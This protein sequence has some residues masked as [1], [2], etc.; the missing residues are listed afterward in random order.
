MKLGESDLK[1][2][3][4]PVFFGYLLGVLTVT[5][6]FLI[7]CSWLVYTIGFSNVVKNFKHTVFPWVEQKVIDLPEAMLQ[8]LTTISAGIEN[9]GNPTNL[10]PHN[11][12]FVSAD[13]ELGHKIKPNVRI[14]ASILKTTKAF[15]FDPPILFYRYDADL[16]DD[17]KAFINSQ[18]RHHFSYSSD[19]DGFRKTLPIVNADKGVLII[20]DSV[21][22]GVGVD[23]K[24]T[25]A[26]SLQKSLGNRYR[27]I[28]A[29]VGGY[30]GQQAFRAAMQLS[31]KYDFGGLIYIACQNDF[32]EAKDWIFE[33]RDVLTK[34]KSIS[35]RFDNNVI[36]ILQTYMEYN[37]RDIF[38]DKGW[39]K[40]KIDKTHQLRQAMPELCKNNG[41]GYYDWTDIVKDYMDQEKSLLSRF[42][43][44]VD[45][46][47]LSPLGNRLMS[48]KLYDIIVSEWQT[49]E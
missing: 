2:D 49:T 34:I 46:V 45:H 43:L 24:F 5:V 37:L 12:I 9:A 22:F 15:N 7:V 44:Y 25:V 41:F 35:N 16:S 13:K 32:H 6:I 11:T 21:S 3:R 47:H 10:A 1:T 29:S 14:S 23:D 19:S 26:S 39:S 28:N 18:S 42:A 40:E 4:S 17:L 33:A 27:V 8:E 48:E 36:V 38:L 31:Q 20:G 30:N